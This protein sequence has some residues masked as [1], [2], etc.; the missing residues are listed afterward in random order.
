MW[1][2]CLLFSAGTDGEFDGLGSL[3]TLGLFGDSCKTS[4]LPERH[5]GNSIE[6]FK[7]YN[8]KSL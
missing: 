5:P 1:R 3:T 6:N 8:L 4:S 7:I 2:L